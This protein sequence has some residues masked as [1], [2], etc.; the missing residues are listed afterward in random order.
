MGEILSVQTPLVEAL[1]SIGWNHV[2]GEGLDRA[3]EQPFVESGVVAALR[4]LNPLI[5]SDPSRIDEVLRPLRALTLAAGEN[6]LVE[7]NRDFA[8]WLR[9]LHDHQF[10][11]TNGS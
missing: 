3:I 5:E 11:G 4:R 9:G 1:A 6:G 8:Q 10:V 2:P 7:T